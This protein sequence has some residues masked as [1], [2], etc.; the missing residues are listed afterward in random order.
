MYNGCIMDKTNMYRASDQTFVERSQNALDQSS[1]FVS[2]VKNLVHN[3]IM[4]PKGK[5]TKTLQRAGEE[6]VSPGSWG[7]V[8]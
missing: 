1:D 6:D 3:F 2:R 7:R 5:S 8:L 4:P